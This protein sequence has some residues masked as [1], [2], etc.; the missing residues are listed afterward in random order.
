MAV[1]SP[2]DSAAPRPGPTELRLLVELPALRKLAD[3]GLSDEELAVSRQLARATVRS[4]RS[5]DALGYRQADSSFHLYLLKLTSER[6]FSE[7]AGL[8]LT[9]GIEHRPVSEER[10]HRMVA[11]ASEHGE[12]VDLLADDM[13]SAAADLLRHHV[14]RHGA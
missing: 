12:I 7:V 11:E 10:G 2:R 3:R 13:V 1:M 9:P 8:L 14:S 6:A 4:A 5:G